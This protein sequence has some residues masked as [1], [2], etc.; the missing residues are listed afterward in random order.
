MAIKIVAEIGINHNGSIENT[1]KLIDLASVC[2]FDYI[3]FQ[4][5]DPELCVPADEKNKLKATPWGEMTYIDYKHKIE[6]NIDDYE[7][8][9]N[10]CHKKNIKW[11]ASVWDI[12]SAQFMRGFSDIVKIPSAL[13]TDIGLLKYCRK[14]FRFLIISTGMSSESEIE[15]AIKV[16]NPDVILHSNSSYPTSTEDIN[17]SYIKF[18]LD[19]WPGKEIGYSGHEEGINATIAAGILNIQWIERHVTL[20]KKMWGSD[21]AASIDPVEM[22]QLVNGIRSME[23]AIGKYGPRILCDAERMKKKSLRK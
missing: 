18:L 4:K 5:R 10:Y 15:T 9:N 19:K 3:K 14:A 12:N 11:F 23:K 16:S 8:I 1:F 20:D 6:F 7:A 21:Q 22:F 17:L 2:G 13:I